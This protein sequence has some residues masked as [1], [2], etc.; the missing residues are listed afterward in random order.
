MGGG[1]WWPRGMARRLMD[2]GR[3][4]VCDGDGG[5]GGAGVGAVAA[6]AARCTAVCR[7]DSADDWVLRVGAGGG[8]VVFW[9]GGIRGAAGD[10]V[11]PAG[12]DYA[13]DVLRGVAAAVHADPDF[14]GID[15][16]PAGRVHAVFH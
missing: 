13:G 4:D 11:V 16:D 9:G 3:G 15:G 1:S 14:C 8:G 10:R 5:V 7:D 12:G 6:Y 2:W